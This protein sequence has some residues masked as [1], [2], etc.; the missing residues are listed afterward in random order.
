MKTQRTS[1]LVSL[2]ALSLLI[3][4]SAARAAD[5]C[6]VD[7]KVEYRDCKA[8]CKEDY[9]AA[10]DACLDRD[11]ACVEV[12][13]AERADCRDATGIDAAIDACNDALDAARQQCRDTYASGTP[14]RDACIDQAQVVAFQ[15]RDQAREDAKPALKECRKQ[16]R[17]CASGCALN[18][19][20]NPT[21]K[22]QCKK[23]ALAAFLACQATCREDFQIAKDGCKNRDHACAE[24]C[25]AE[26]AECRRPVRD[27][28]NA[29]VAACKATRD[30]AVDNCKALYADGTPERDQCIDNA[31][32][33]AFQCRDQAHEDARPGLAA[34]RQEFRTCIGA[35][36][37]A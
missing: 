31:Q 26:R 17:T 15:C 9:Q 2:A 1:V 18:Q 7:A 19:P 30:A 3:G 32:V 29:D 11:H 27:Q 13:R 8:G 24:Q 20:P 16:F 23:D 10:K 34:C 35:C 5:P 14:E 22:K 12:C 6:M 37:P 21:G 36:P 28:F 4:A 25:R 33:A